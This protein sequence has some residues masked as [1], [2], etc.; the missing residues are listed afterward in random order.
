[1]A[2]PVRIDELTAGGSLSAGAAVAVVQGNDTV[3]KAAST[4][5]TEAESFTQSGAGA[6]ARTAQSKMRDFVSVKDFGAA[7]DLT[8]DTTDI[9]S[10]LDIG[11][12]MLPFATGYSVSTLSIPQESQFV[13][14]GR[15]APLVL[16]GA[17]GIEVAGDNASLSQLRIDGQISSQV[18]FAAASAGNVDLRDLDITTTDATGGIGI[19][20]NAASVD[21]W[22]ILGSRIVTNDYAFLLNDSAGGSKGIVLVGNIIDSRTAEA[23]AFNT[24]TTKFEDG[25]V[26]GNLTRNQNAGSGPG[27][28]YSLAHSDGVAYVGNVSQESRNEAIH[29]EDGTENS[30]LVGNVL[31]LCRKSGIKI[32]IGG[33]GSHEVDARPIA[34]IGNQ[35]EAASS[36]AD[37]GGI[38]VV[39]DA[40]GALNSCPIV[41]NVVSGFESG[42]WL[43]GTAMHLANGNTIQNCT[44]AIRCE[45]GG[46]SLTKIS[47][48]NFVE[49]CTTLL[50]AS[51]ATAHMVQAGKFICRTK[52][53]NIILKNGSTIRPGCSVEGFAWP[54]T[55]L[56]QAGVNTY[57]DLFP[58]PATGRFAGKI[59][60][61]TRN[62]AAAADNAWYSADVSWDGTTLTITN[63]INEVN[64]ALSITTPGLRVNGGSLQAG[65][66]HAG[67]ITVYLEM[68]FDGIYMV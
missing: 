20:L 34:I 63:P 18:L 14:L 62:Q 4:F 50:F 5:I 43:G 47:G 28:T 22:M 16:S 21:R 8:N 2:A 10:A 59:T 55:Q 6:T 25:V 64:G 13:G 60:V 66:F 65:Y 53:T 46:T 54:Q 49:S 52:P 56:L 12:A 36:V 51:S 35:I 19:Q 29:I 42:L 57:A 45:T 38:Y 40:D 1:M 15:G 32:L 23:I 39:L 44:N 30:L 31:K 48:T 26:V 41:G 27:F 11:A 17:S 68:N 9:Q 3:R 61:Q 58:A 7:G 24:P 33:I 67:A 37:E